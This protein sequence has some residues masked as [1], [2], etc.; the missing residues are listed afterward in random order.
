MNRAAHR[1]VAGIGVGTYLASRSGK[2]G[3]TTVNPILGGVAA[4]VFTNLPDLL[5]PATSPNHRAF[6]HSI[7]FAAIVGA[8]FHRL[9]QWQPETDSE[10]FW[11]DAAMLAA[12][13]YLI[14]LAMDIT[15]PKSLP[16][17]GIGK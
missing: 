5:E 7:A 2:A 12:L 17:F 13:A 14:H 6:F 15:T 4:A 11:R 8:C 10:R 3:L 16:L 9:N 1:V